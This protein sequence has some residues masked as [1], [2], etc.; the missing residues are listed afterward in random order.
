MKAYHHVLPQ[1]RLGTG[2]HSLAS[3]VDAVNNDDSQQQQHHNDV[4]IEFSLIVVLSRDAHL[5]DNNNNASDS[6][7]D[8]DDD[9]VESV[10]SNISILLGKKLRGFGKGFFN[11]LG[12]KLE[13]GEHC[14]PALGAARELEE[15]SGIR[16]P[17]SVMQD[18]FVGVINFTFEDDDINR[19]MRVHLFCVFVSLSNNDDAISSNGTYAADNGVQSGVQSTTR[20]Y[21]HNTTT[22]IHPKQIRGCDEI[23]PK[24]FHNIHDIPL[25]QMFADD[26]LWL[27]MLLSHYNEC[28][29]SHSPPQK[30]MFD[31]WFH[32]RAGGTT[33]NSIMHHYIKI[34]GG[35]ETVVTTAKSPQQKVT[36]EKR[37]FHE[38]HVN[39][40]HSPSIKEFKEN[41]A[42]ANAVR[43]FM[44]D[45]KRMEYIVDVAG[46]HGALAALFLVL[47]PTCHT[48]VV[49]D[50]A[51]CPSGKHGVREAWSKFWTNESEKKE[52]RYRHECLRTGLRGEL[53]SIL[54]TKC[55]TSITVVACHACQHLT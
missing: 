13:K 12:G 34:N 11:S 36:L 40:I 45:E 44:K 41:W 28:G 46:G 49:I 29:K 47:I 35:S 16:I 5:H 43:K 4:P 42:M 24:W 19:A 48:A 55:T 39:H 3:Y 30:L 53:D 6:I 31:A 18:A 10:N 1:S 17:L 52:L 32:F 8:N 25:N 20:Q 23:E 15:E 26:S 54:K 9:D 22:I 2:H 14:N 37:L 38:L 33:T 50:P 7:D 27:T 51:Q 21:A